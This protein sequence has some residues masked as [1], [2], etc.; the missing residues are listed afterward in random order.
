MWG[1]WSSWA[2]AYP[3]KT[4][5][6]PQPFHPCQPCQPPAPPCHRATAPVYNPPDWRPPDRHQPDW[7][8]T[9]RHKQDYGSHEECC[10]ERQL[11][12]KTLVVIAEEKLQKVGN[13]VIPAPLGVTCDAN[14]NLSHQITLVP[15]GEPSFRPVV[16]KNKLVN[17]GFLTVRVEVTDNDP[18]PCPDVRKFPPVIVVIPFQSI[19]DIPGICPGDHVQEFAR[20]EALLVSGVPGACS[21]THSGTAVQLDLKA[22]LEVHLIIAREAVISVAADLIHFLPPTCCQ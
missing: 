9:D 13:L 19:H 17:E 1:A 14:G 8:P 12:L 3:S 7:Q 5:R 15:I 6:G 2:T 4:N 11:T 22:I 10:K 18:Q 16:L 21:P 20:I